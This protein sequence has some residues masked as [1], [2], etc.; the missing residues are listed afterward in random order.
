MT[1]KTAFARV[2][3]AMIQDKTADWLLSKIDDAI[4]DLNHLAAN[5]PIQSRH[6]DSLANRAGFYGHLLNKAFVSQ[7]ADAESLRDEEDNLIGEDG[8]CGH[9]VIGTPKEKE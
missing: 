2:V 6:L 5:E 4:E 3:P 9:G 7:Y 1:D 8:R